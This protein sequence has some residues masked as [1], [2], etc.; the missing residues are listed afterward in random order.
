M[1]AG[2]RMMETEILRLPIEYI[3]NEEVV[4]GLESDLESIKND[5]NAQ[6]PPWLHRQEY[7]DWLESEIEKWKR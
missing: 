3:S 2:F 4:S 7:I 1:E 5:P 6:V